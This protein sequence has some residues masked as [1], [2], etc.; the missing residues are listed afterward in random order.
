[1]T[2]MVKVTSLLIKAGTGV[3]YSFGVRALTE[4]KMWSIKDMHRLKVFSGEIKFWF[5]VTNYEDNTPV[6]ETGSKAT[7]VGG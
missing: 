4:M 3:G 2:G 1:M 7:K 6:R 5:Q